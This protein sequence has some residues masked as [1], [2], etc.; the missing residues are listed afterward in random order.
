M[1]SWLEN[2]L[3]A[4]T[5]DWLIAFWHHPPYTKGSHDSDSESNLVDMRENAV[6]ILE[7]YGVDLVLS[8]HSH[9]YERSYLIDGHY[10][11]SGSFRQSMKVDGGNGREDGTGVYEKNGNGAANQGAVYA[12]AGSSGKTEGGSLNHP[13][14][15]MSLNTL[16]SM[17]LDVNGDRLDGYFVDSSGATRDYFAITKGSDTTPPALLSV[18]AVNATTVLA[19]F[20]EKLDQASAGNVTNYSI[21]NGVGLTAATLSQNQLQVTLTTTAIQPAVVHTLTVNNVTDVAGNPIAAGSQGNFQLSGPPA[22]TTPPQLLSVSAVDETTVEVT[23][24]E[25]LD[26]GTAENVA[27]YSVNR[28]VG[29]VAAA[30]SQNQLTVTLATTAIQ[31]NLLHTLTVNNITDIAGNPVAAGSQGGFQ[32]SG[33]PADTTPP[34]LVSVS[35]VDET[36]VEVTFSEALDEGTAENIANYSINRGVSVNSATLNANQRQL[37]LETSAMQADILHT[38][39]VNNISD[40]AGNAINPNSTGSFRLAGST[41]ADTEPPTT[42]GGVRQTGAS[43]TSVSI[44]WGLSSD[45]VGVTGYRVRRDGALAGTTPGTSFQDGALKAA[46]AYR[47]TVSA[48][49]AAGNES[50]DS[51]PLLVITDSA[52]ASEPAGTTSGGGGMDLISMLLLLL[53]A[54]RKRLSFH[55]STTESRNRKFALL[56]IMLIAPGLAVP[57]EDLH[58]RIERLS[59]RIDAAPADYQLHVRRGELYR[60]HADFEGALADFA[61][62]ARTGPPEF[63]SSVDFLRGR[64]WLDAGRPDI[65]LPVLDRFVK[66][67]PEHVGGR[68]VRARVHEALDQFEAAIWDYSVAIKLQDRPSP[69]LY[70][71]RARLQASDRVNRPDDSLRG[72]DE[73]IATLGPLVTLLQFAIELETRR[74]NFEAAMQRIAALPERVQSQPRWLVRRADLLQRAGRIEEAQGVYAAAFVAIESL[75]KNRRNTRANTALAATVAASLAVPPAAESPVR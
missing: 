69:D 52:A 13:A 36:S 48:I 53:A 38:L 37:M 60:Q 16:G 45:N 27:N 31:P 65:A 6:P 55:P 29:V 30:L 25:A 8:G 43:A 73:G 56:C 39:T 57:D 19:T 75:P 12:V 1:L 32:L 23:F 10:G 7:R 3:A 44:A 20:S 64:T 51:S 18:E 14:M 41:P 24:S 11:S 66:A 34:E 17:V 35:A 58:L 40:V 46:T 72:I 62:A 59:A 33:P 5:S 49:D 54:A 15:F 28:G 63:Q 42:P 26:E 4:T 68:L 70:L 74:D 2:D 22:D 21:N 9:S 71:D 47:Y 61:E 50:P 67:Q